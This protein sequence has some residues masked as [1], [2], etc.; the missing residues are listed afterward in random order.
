MLTLLAPDVV[1]W[2]D[3][4]GVV[5]A[6]RRPL[7]G[8]DHVARWLLGVLAKPA[9]QGVEMRLAEINGEP[10]LLLVHGGVNAGALT[11]EATDGRITA[12]RLTVNPEKLRGLRP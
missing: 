3:G 12:L 6:A 5:T 9:V 10:G 11:F 4:G 2:S 1:S 7:Y 8:P